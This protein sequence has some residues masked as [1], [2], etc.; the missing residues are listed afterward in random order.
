MKVLRD[1][2]PSGK[3]FSLEELGWLRDGLKPSIP[4]GAYYVLADVS[5]LPGRTSKEKAMFTLSKTGVVSVPDDAFF[6]KS[7]GS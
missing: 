7:G 1:S 6:H 2:N 4:Q 5:H 3:V